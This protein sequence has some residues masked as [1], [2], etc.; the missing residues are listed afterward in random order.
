M[1]RS[2]F[3]CGILAAVLLTA[4][5]A[6]DHDVN[7]QSAAADDLI[8]EIIEE[9]GTLAET[10]ADTAAKV[11]EAKVTEAK[12][13]EAKATEV[14]VTEAPA[15]Y[16]EEETEYDPDS[17]RLFYQ[18]LT[19]ASKDG[20]MGYIDKTGNW[21]IEPQFDNAHNFYAGNIA[22]VRID[23]KYGCIDRN[24][25]YIIEPKMGYLG[26]D[27]SDEHGV[28]L[29][30]VDSQGNSKEGIIDPTTG[31]W[32]IE[33][34]FES[35]GIFKG[36]LASF[37]STD[38]DGNRNIGFIDASGSIVVPPI[39]YRIGDFSNGMTAVC[40]NNKFGYI[41]DTG[42]VVIE[43]QFRY[44]NDFYDDGIAYIQGKNGGYGFIDKSGKI[45]VEPELYEIDYRNG[46]AENGLA[47]AGVETSEE[48]V[49]Y[50]F[51]DKTGKWVIE[52]TFPRARSFSKNG[53]AAAA[54]IDDSGHRIWG[55]IDAGG[56]FVIEPVFNIAK[57]FDDTGLA[58]ISIAEQDSDGKYIYYDGIIDSNGDFVAEPKYGFIYYD[59]ITGKL[60]DE[61]LILV[62]ESSF[63]KYGYIDRNGKEV[64]KATKYANLG[65]FAPNGLARVW[66]DDGKIGFINKKGEIVIDFQFDH[67]DGFYDDGYCV[68]VIDGKYGIINSAGD[69]IAEPEFESIPGQWMSILE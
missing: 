49:M 9:S 42:A 63:G 5:V 40:I 31:K 26:F 32:V 59:D 38:A 68:V 20:K 62:G 16:E 39:Y 21:V 24:G 4:C 13:T 18:G 53:L 12:T 56:S 43:P 69:Y 46:F 36:S 7:S 34:K 60:Y 19:T 52:P 47:L 58:V 10:A 30:T 27:Y 6:D 28:Y 37:W 44:A 41:D 54:V 3:F 8:T 50:G 22:I 65:R 1:R 64:I 2:T 14:K 25:N 33:P 48:D 61:D 57:D 51:I 17:A 45:I 35:L 11:S 29:T 15:Q 23:K 66:N 55:Y 67:A